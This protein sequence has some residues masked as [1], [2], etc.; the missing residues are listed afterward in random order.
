MSF[1]QINGNLDMRSAAVAMVD[2]SGTVIAGEFRLGGREHF[3]RKSQFCSES[4]SPSVLVLRNTR[5]TRLMDSMMAWPAQG[6]L[7]L[8]GFRFTYLGGFAADNDCRSGTEDEMRGRGMDWWDSW[9][10]RDPTNSPT[11]YEQLAAALTAA[12]DRS[13]ADEI[14]YLG[15]VRAREGER[16]ATWIF[17]GFLQY[18]AGFGIGDRTFRVIYW[19]L[20]ISIC[21]SFYLWKAVPAARKHGF[22]WCLG[23]SLS[24]L[25]PVIE[26][27]KEFSD[28]FNDPER[29]RLT[30]WQVFVFSTF[31]IIGFVLGA[32]LVAAVSG[33]TQKS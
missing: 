11:P 6:S 32:I 22:L 14:R 25:L 31:S 30:S 33:L 15:R 16:G 12:G 13:S 9:V 17:S 24:R 19:V 26:L 8:G 29:A 2:L 28:F 27:N 21:G 7:Y 3:G 10:R 1:A 5:V 4:P 18:A 20:A 23:A